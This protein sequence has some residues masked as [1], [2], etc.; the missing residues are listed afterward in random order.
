MNRAMLRLFGLGLALTSGMLWS[1]GSASADFQGLVWGMSREQAAKSFKLPHEN[2]EFLSFEYKT[3]NMNFNGGWVLFDHLGRLVG[4]EMTLNPKDYCESLFDTYRKIY[5]RPV[6]DQTKDR[7]RVAIWHN[8]SQNNKI[9]LYSSWIEWT[10]PRHLSPFDREGPNYFLCQISYQPL[11]PLTESDRYHPP[12]VKLT[13]A[14]GG[15]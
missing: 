6:S 5:G 7:N 11:K 15:L 4:I 2:D 8:R 12:P 1:V 3:G 10:G 9:Q 14:P 13:P